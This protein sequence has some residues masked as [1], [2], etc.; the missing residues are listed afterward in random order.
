LAQT[1][2]SPESGG[3][4]GV[5]ILPTSQED[6]AV[7]Y[8]RPKRA[9]LPTAPRALPAMTKMNGLKKTHTH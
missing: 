4:G 7:G 6:H 5:G 3:R 2:T 1:S 8:G 9:E